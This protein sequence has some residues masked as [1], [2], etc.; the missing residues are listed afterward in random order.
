M[1]DRLSRIESQL[2]ALRDQ[3]DALQRRLADLEEHP[4]TGPVEAAAAIEG[5]APSGVEGP[6]AGLGA[7]GRGLDAGTALTFIGRTLVVMA[8]AYLLRAL[9]ESGTLAPGIG[10]SVGAAYALAWIVMADRAGARGRRGSAA[11]HGL[12]CVLIG[13]P[14]LLEATVRFRFLS[15]EASATALTG[16]AAVS[17]GVAWRQRLQG[18]GWITTL[19]ALFT[20]VVL[21][22]LTAHIAPYA[23]YL[24][25]LGVATLW[26]GYVLDWV[27]LRWPVA[28][29][30]DLAVAALALRGISP[31]SLDS[32]SAALSVQ[33]LLLAAYLG[34][35]AARTLFRG[36]DIIPFEIVQS[37]AA[38]LVGLGGAAFVSHWTGVGR[39]PLGIATFLLGVGCYAV[40]IAFVERRQRRRRNFHF[41]A[42]VALVFTMTGAGMVLSMTALA[43]ALAALAV[44]A[45]GA[46]RWLASLTL[47]AH[48]AAY[49]FA[50]VV[51]SGLL[52]HVSH[53][54]GMPMTQPWPSVEI[55]GLFVLAAAILVTW[56]LLAGGT[57]PS[58]SPF[59]RVP[60]LTML[61]LSVG[62]VMGVAVAWGAPLLG[63]GGAA[64][65][66][67]AVATLRTAVMVVAT[68]A[69]ARAA[70]WPRLL[71]AGWLIYPLLV[72][73]GVKFLLEDFR[74]SR[75]S[76]L[77]VAFALYGLALIVAPRLRRRKA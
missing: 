25:L 13:F 49:A 64:E 68:L 1:E 46:S 5:P 21:M 51:A 18:L 9:T 20:A 30:T 60:G 75:P 73:T 54:F 36:R 15:H 63:Q 41:Y 52:N 35:F 8:G 47:R 27:A 23:L 6:A 28:L 33:V 3:V 48:A 72:A 50:S 16:F 71:E 26:M 7:V 59:A 17:L 69:L 57:G 31:R 2:Q 37:V 55:G 39:I 67:G 44:V 61:A 32:P 10:L 34:S 12:A 62:G 70:R 53:G 43:L 74:S 40:A 19:G 77:F 58:Q 56:V 76:T 42:A 29:A 66:A 65:A 24:I 11:F 22:T 45:A 4:S 38:L 14:L